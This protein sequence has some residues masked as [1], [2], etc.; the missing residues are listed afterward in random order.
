MGGVFEIAF[1]PRDWHHMPNQND[2][3]HPISSCLFSLLFF[4]LVANF[5][6]ILPSF[7]V[8]TEKEHEHLT[9]VPEIAS[10]TK[11]RNA[12]LQGSQAKQSRSHHKYHCKMTCISE[13]SV[14]RYPLFVRS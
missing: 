7:T 8:L 13:F 6:G 14:A 12:S 5:F 4:A 3:P 11:A 2:G 9:T 10:P 1:Q